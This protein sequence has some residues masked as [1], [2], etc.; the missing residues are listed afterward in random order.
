MSNPRASEQG[1]GRER[2]RQGPLFISP[3]PDGDGGFAALTHARTHAQAQRRAW[4]ELPLLVCTA[5]FVFG[6]RSESCFFNF[7][8]ICLRSSP[9]AH[10]GRKFLVCVIVVWITSTLFCVALHESRGWRS[11]NRRLFPMEVLWA[12][13]WQGRSSLP[14]EMK[15]DLESA[16]SSSAVKHSPRAL[17]FRP[18]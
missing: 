2:R 6:G 5:D 16:M 8:L 12:T 3:R 7:P 18:G 15:G 9:S 1:R 11:V 10:A 17:S 14:V 4:A 13:P